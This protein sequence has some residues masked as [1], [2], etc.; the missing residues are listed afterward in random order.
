MFSSLLIDIA[1][2]IGIRSKTIIHREK[3]SLSNAKTTLVNLP[4]RLITTEALSLDKIKTDLYR[5]FQRVLIKQ[6]ETLS[7]MLSSIELIKPENTLSRGYSIVRSEGKSIK[8]SK[9]LKKG[10]QLEIELHKGKVIAEVLHFNK[11]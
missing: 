8:D 9:E 3:T 10:D 5:E 11:K 4:A 2:R 7:G 6:K 1:T